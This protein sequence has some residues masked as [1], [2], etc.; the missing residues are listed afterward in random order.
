MAWNGKREEKPAEMPIE[1][2]SYDQL[3]ALKIRIDQEL[4]GRGSA[5]L[6]ALKEKMML[7]AD[8]QGTTVADLFGIRAQR[9]IKEKRKQRAKYRDPETGDEWSGRG[10][11]PSW[12]QAKLDAGASKEDFLSQ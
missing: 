3:L 6:Q 7:I 11:P 2:M 9:K 12:M 8:A 4:T 1:L 5:E 10:K